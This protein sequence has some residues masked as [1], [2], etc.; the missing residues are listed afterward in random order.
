MTIW[1]IPIATLLVAGLAL[2][3]CGERKTVTETTRTT[4]V[5]PA[6]PMAPP[7]TETTVT[8]EVR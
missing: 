8:R 2:T 5:A 1:N 7:A 6:A 3:A 4:T